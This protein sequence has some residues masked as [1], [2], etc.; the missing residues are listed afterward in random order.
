M[1]D[2]VKNFL[3]SS[4]PPPSL[5]FVPPPSLLPL[6]P[7]PLLTGMP[8]FMRM[9]GER[10]VTR[11]CIRSGSLSKSSGAWSFIVASRDSAYA[12][13]TPYHVLGSPLERERRSREGKEE[14]EGKE[15][16]EGKEEGEEEGKE[17]EGRGGGE[18]GGG[19]GGGEGGEGGGRKGGRERDIEHNTYC[20]ISIPSSF[21][22]QCR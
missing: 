11:W 9:E 4:L 7:P 8:C 22:H 6:L 5:L 16:K 20:T 14:E 19:R 1:P 13:G 2:R 10:M 3:F 15:G 18:G 17:E 12:G 21:P